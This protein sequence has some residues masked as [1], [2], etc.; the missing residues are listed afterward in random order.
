M[1]IGIVP[2]TISQIRRAVG[3]SAGLKRAGSAAE[4]ARDVG[5]EEQHHGRK[6]PDVAGDVERL[7]EGSLGVPAEEFPR[8]N[9]VSGA[10]NRQELGEALDDAEQS[11]GDEVHALARRAAAA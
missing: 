8:Q 1:T 10:R 2:T 9:Q 11:R 3:I 5:A 6:R 4:Q 7:P